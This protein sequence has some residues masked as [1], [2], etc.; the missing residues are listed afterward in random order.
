MTTTTTDRKRFAALRWV[1]QVIAW[2]VILG[3]TSAIVVAVLIPRIAGATPYTILT[4]SME[5]NYPP[6]TLVV[7]KPTPVEE[8]G[9]GTVITY[10]LES[11]RRATVT[12]RVTSVGY[13]ADGE[14]VFT[15]RGDANDSDDAEPVIPV[16]IRGTLWYAVPKLGWMSNALEQ[17]QRNT[18][19]YVVAGGLGAYALWMFGSA[20]RDR[21]RRRDGRRDDTTKEQGS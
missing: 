4:S 11:G 3:A 18:A 12:H 19:V 16:Q 20:L 7:V 14:R 15:T 8:I 2:V 9:V 21:T 13:R 5:P 10:Q 6:G 17:E 1:G